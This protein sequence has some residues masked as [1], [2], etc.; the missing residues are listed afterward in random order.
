MRRA[1]WRN[2]PATWSGP[3][4]CRKPRPAMPAIDKIIDAE[5]PFF[6]DG[7]DTPQR[8]DF[9]GMQTLTVRTMAESGE[10]IV[11]FRPRPLDAG[12]RIPLQLQMLE[13]D[14]LDQARTMGL[15]NGHVMEGVQFDEIGRR[16]A[17]WLFTLSPGRR[18][19][20]QSARRHCQPAGS[21]RSDHARLPRAPARP[22]AR[23]AVAR[24]GDDGAPGSGR[25]LRRRARAQEDRG[26]RHRV[27]RAAGGHRRRPAGPRRYRPV[28]R[29]AGR[30]FPAGHGRVPE[31][32]P[33]RSSSTIRRR[34]AAT[35]NTR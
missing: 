12:L 28:E 27:R 26:L 6:A 18:A 34:P 33:G 35:A 10:A 15:V 1:P 23:R 3:A 7:C 29:A 30:E 24:A 2:W 19:D 32:R 16:V 13:A 20:P 8:L 25:L 4:S 31:A 14:F 21:G 9:Y 22:G 5:W 11:R 17:Y